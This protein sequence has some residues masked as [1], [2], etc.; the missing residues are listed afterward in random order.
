MRRAV[1]RA[2]KPRM[3]TQHGRHLA[4]DFLARLDAAKPWK[5]PGITAPYLALVLRFLHEAY[6]YE[7]LAPRPR[8]GRGRPPEP[9]AALE[10]QLLAVLRGLPS[11]SRADRLR[12]AARIASGFGGYA[13]G[14]RTLDRRTGARRA[15]ARRQLER[16][17]AEGADPRRFP[18]LLS[19]DDSAYRDAT[20]P[21]RR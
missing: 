12:E 5:T 19:L 10:E 11:L 16:W 14:A 20:K 18:K 1:L 13:L 21:T 7:Y 2:L 6:I 17:V 8:S 3:Q 15:A 9:G 4:D